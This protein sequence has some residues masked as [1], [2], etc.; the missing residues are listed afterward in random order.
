MKVYLQAIRNRE[1]A[2]RAGGSQKSRFLDGLQGVAAWFFALC[3]AGHGAHAQVNV[4]T[5][6]NDIARTGQNL[7]ETILTTANVNPTQFGKLF[8]QPVNGEIYAQPL[9]VSNVAIPGNG[10]HNVVYVTT[11]AGNPNGT[12]G[13]FPG[14]TVYAFDADTNGGANGS[15]LW[16]VSLLTNTAPAGTYSSNYGVVGT[17]VIDPV[18][19]T[20]YLVS[21]DLQSSVPIYRFHALDIT[22]GAEKFGAPIQIQGSVPGTGS[23]SV[24]GVLTFNPTYQLQRPALLFLNG[25][26]YVPFGS[27]GDQGPWHGWIFS[28]D[29]NPATQTLQRVN[30]FCTTANGSGGGIWMGGAGL[31]A[32]VN[33][34]AKPY[35]RM[36][37]STGNGSYSAS[38]PYS[39][40]MSYGMS[41]LDLDLTGGVLTVE[42]EFTPY[43]EATLEGQDGDLGSG[44]PVLLPTQTLA[45]GQTLNALVQIGKSG[46]FYILDRENNTDG[47][48]NPATD[49][50]PAGLGGFDDNN[51]QIVQEV[52]S[53]LT[54]GFN[55]G[56]GVWGTEA[57][58][59]NNIYSGGT[60]AASAAA[61]AGASNSLTAYSFVNGV[62]STAPTSQSPDRY[63]YPG[64]T[65]SVSA[66]GTANGIVWA[67][68]NSQAAP[69]AL[70]AYDATNLANIL[71]SSSDNFSRDSSGLPAEYAVPTIANGKVYVGAVSQF[72]VYG[73]L[74]ATPTAPFPVISP[75]SGVFTNSQTVTITDALSSATIYY[76]T[77]GTVPTSSSPVYQNQPIVVSTNE[78]IT[79]IASATGYLVSAPASATYQSST[80]PANPVF[81]LTAGTYTGTQSL[82]ITDSTPGAVIY[83]TIDGPAPTTASTAY[84][85]SQPPLSVSASETVRA[86]AIAPGPYSSSVVSATY[87][88]HTID[89]SQG[90]A[91]ADGPMQFNGSTDLDDFRLQLTNGGT[92]EAGSAF[93]ATPVNIQ[94]FTT[95][96]T[97]QLSNPS[98]DGMTFTIQNN[99][100]GALG[101]YGG[102]LGYQGISNSLAIK[103][104]LYSNKGEGPDSTGL[105]TGGASP[106]LPAI[107]LTGTGIDLHSG[108]YINAT[109]TYDGTNLTV[110]LTDA[111]TLAT[112]SQSFVINI[113]AVVGGNTA[114]VG[115]TG[116]TGG[117]TSSQKVTSWV[118]LAGRPAPNYTAGFAPGSLTLNGG[119]SF[120]GTRL[121]LTDGQ[122]NEARGAFFTT[123]VN[124]QQF[125]TSFDF[126]LTNAA[127]DGFTFTI[128]GKGPTAV[129]TDGGSLGYAGIPTSVAVK[130]DF[131]INASDGGD[132]TGLYTNGAQPTKPSISLSPAGINLLSGDT[133]HVLLTY[134]GATLTVV[135]T[136]TV[137]NAS[138]TQNYTVNIPSI[139]GGPTAY[140]GFTAGDGGATAIQEILDWSY[141]PLAVTKPA[142]FNGAPTTMN[143]GATLV[144][145]ALQLTDGNQNEARSAFTTTPLNIQ[146]FTTS[147]EFQLTNP[148]A[149]GF[150]FT[151]QGAGPTEVGTPSSGL[152][153]DGIPR[154][155]AVKFDLY[156]NKGE[157]PDSTGL[158]TNGASPTIPAID[159]SSTGINLHS[160]DIFNAQLTYNGTTLAVVITDTVT[161]AT[162]TQTYTVNIP[163]IVGGPTAYVGFTGGTGGLTAVQQIFNWS[164]AL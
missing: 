163:S 2:R 38:Y 1:T 88:I 89:F 70:S 33:N 10:T 63:S 79:A 155:V 41:V 42:D 6:H 140:V 137:T 128:Q 96:F 136:D 134:N 55:W 75:S 12:P 60:N 83:Y 146:Q 3:L 81:S 119:A 80:T 145:S 65:P 120:N 157:G 35:G 143:G 4:L 149:D 5:A 122:E 32:E 25:V 22:T 62:L 21:S 121:R 138:A 97:F 40:T 61:F 23:A 156:N 52:Q 117:L 13:L 74:G 126:Q 98:A 92:S 17:P 20:M 47:S 108:D 76:T 112:W 54:A 104:D 73:L 31:A 132:S 59:N 64:P 114:Y 43:N 44:G 161:N 58:W 53:P 139:V 85:P 160:G 24:G 109:L 19:Q 129:G 9:Y 94:Q 142:F 159:L 102:G 100:P 150:T 141:S 46:M 111:I 39:N 87:T 36:F 162:A 164:Y 123:P 103:F 116:G 50:S 153:Y 91:L 16:Q 105:Y 124:V 101:G 125:T 151:I 37:L 127:A 68:H 69:V 30:V 135:I 72:S 15:P 131:Y 130:F 90:F 34:P 26:V 144:G 48:N 27:V 29:V 118:Y 106:T 49:Y 11:T 110:I 115:F 95:N 107:N 86:I 84:N 152:G 113:P 45:S 14:D 28:F 148:N 7:N 56:A 57:Y 78:T 99:G 154:S 71:Y 51:D 93:Y 67:L 8:S 133:F 18:S 158:Y 147:F 66:N 77:D 82:T